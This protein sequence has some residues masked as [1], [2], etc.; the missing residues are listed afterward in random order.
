MAGEEGKRRRCVRAATHPLLW[1]SQRVNYV[2]KRLKWRSMVLLLLRAFNDECAEEL[3]TTALAALRIINTN[4]SHLQQ[5]VGPASCSLDFISSCCCYCIVCSVFLPLRLYP[6]P[7]LQ[8]ARHSV[9]RSLSHLS[10]FPCVWKAA[11]SSLAHT[12]AHSASQRPA[13]QSSQDA[14][15]L[16]CSSTRWKVYFCA[17]NISHIPCLL[18]VE[19]WT[20]VCG[21]I[22]VPGGSESRLQAD[23]VK[24]AG[25]PQRWGITLSNLRCR[26]QR[27]CRRRSEIQEKYKGTVLRPTKCSKQ[28]KSVLICYYICYYTSCLVDSACSQ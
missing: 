6:S 1:N 2:W 5:E 23:N 9:T 14:Q 10:W 16:F 21:A 4:Y 20:I 25:F 27:R 19:N 15:L 28:T 18:S 11:Q 12:A 3:W 7:A 26:E 13:L 8:T 24:G 22:R 17:D